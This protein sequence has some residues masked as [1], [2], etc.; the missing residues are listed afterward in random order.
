MNKIEK[1]WFNFANETIMYDG[2]I[3]MPVN[4][5]ASAMG[6]IIKAEGKVNS[7]LWDSVTPNGTEDRVWVRAF[8]FLSGIQTYSDI[9]KGPDGLFAKACVV[10]LLQYHDFTK[11]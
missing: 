5:F 1:A 7:A 4:D 9:L 8:A 2:S 11:H 3:H 6:K 10:K